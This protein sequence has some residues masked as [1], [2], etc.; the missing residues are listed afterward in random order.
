MAGNTRKGTTVSQRQGRS[1][2]GTTTPS[3]SSTPP[4]PLGAAAANSPKQDDTDVDCLLSSLSQEN[5]SLVKII[6]AII[7][8]QFKIEIETLKDDLRRKETE[9]E[10][11]QNEV[12]DLKIKVTS[13]ETQ[14]DDVEQYERRDTIILNGP[15]VPPETPTENT[16]SVTVA[17]IREHLKINL[18]ENDLSV[19]HRLGPK[20]NHTRPIIVKLVNRSLKYDLVGACIKLKPGIYV[21][22]SLTPKRLNIMKKVLAIRKQH[23]QKFQQCY[24]KDGK[25][26]IKLKN[27]TVKHTIVDEIT[28]LDFLGKYPSMKDT[29][30]ELFPST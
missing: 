6:K 23:R 18:K 13:L 8:Q 15:S 20:H 2:V 21:N 10:Q 12:K 22:E 5:K 17:T 26:T 7:S 27:S 29:Y 1:G 24:T 16:V 11:L 30:Q 9:V 4:T 28:L 19:A 3:R 25:I 14:I